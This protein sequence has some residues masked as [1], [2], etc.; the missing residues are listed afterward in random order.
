MNLGI[1]TEIE[2]TDANTRDKRF[3]PNLKGLRD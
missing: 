1:K 3:K 2:N